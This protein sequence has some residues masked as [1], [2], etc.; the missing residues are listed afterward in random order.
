MGNNGIILTEEET[1]LGSVL[2]ENTGRVEQVY[3]DLPD[4]YV[5]GSGFSAE[6]VEKGQAYFAVSF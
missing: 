5:Y 2:E 1:L 6:E 4:I 3:A